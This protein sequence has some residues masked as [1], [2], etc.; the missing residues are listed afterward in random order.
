MRVAYCTGFWNTNVGNGFFSLGTEYV[1]KKIL[2]DENVTVVSDM[3]TYTNSIGKRHY[4]HNKQLN[5]F[6]FLDVDYLVLSGPMLSKYFV[7][8]WKESLMSLRKRGIGYILLSAGIMKLN[9]D[10]ERQLATFLQECPPQILTT[11]DSI[12]F[13][14]FSKYAVY[15]YDGICFSFFTPDLYK[16]CSMKSLQPYIALNFDKIEEPAIWIDDK[17]KPRADQSFEFKNKLFYLKHTRS[18]RFAMKTD[19]FTDALIYVLSHLPAPKRPNQLE[20]YRLLRTDHR[21]HPHFRHKIYRYD[22][23]FC[24]DLPYAYLNLYANAACTLSDRVHACAVTLAFGNHAMLY[25]M[26]NRL[27]LLERVGAED[28]RRR[29]V[30][31]DLEKLSKE[32]K[33]LL[34]WLEEAFGCLDRQ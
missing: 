2:G 12:V 26:T 1:L 18:T 28:I 25:S 19:R 10:E 32:K 8:L 7:S 27:G 16:P 17:A 33:K 9:N 29:P 22:N 30:T 11:R 23:S 14:K 21:F 24:A 5:Y 4:P 15:A 20:G 13:E 6:P 3:Q 31:I 34:N